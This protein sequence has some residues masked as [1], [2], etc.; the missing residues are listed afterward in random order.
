M[1]RN[2]YTLDIDIL[3]LLYIQIQ[4]IDFNLIYLLY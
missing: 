3:I 1:D 2:N 4:M